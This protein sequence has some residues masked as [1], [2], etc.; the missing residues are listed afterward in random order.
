MYRHGS[1]LPVDHISVWGT[2]ILKSGKTQF[3]FINTHVYHWDSMTIF[4]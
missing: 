3:K 4:E 2:D 1:N